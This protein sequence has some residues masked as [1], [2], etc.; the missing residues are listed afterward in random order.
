MEERGASNIGTCI[1]ENETDL[2]EDNDEEDGIER[3]DSI[4]DGALNLNTL[5]AP[6]R[7]KFTRKFRHSCPEFD[8]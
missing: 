5:V 7:S 4:N 3:E 1:K 2:P 6:S 8:N